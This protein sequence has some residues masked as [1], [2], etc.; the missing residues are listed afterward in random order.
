MGWLIATLVALD[1]SLKKKIIDIRYQRDHEG[2]GEQ[3]ES[4]KKDFHNSSFFFMQRYCVVTK[5][6]QE[7]GI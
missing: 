4:D 7:C 6:K 2:D 3:A 5:G 1:P